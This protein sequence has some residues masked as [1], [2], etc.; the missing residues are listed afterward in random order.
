LPPSGL[1]LFRE[2]ETIKTTTRLL[3]LIAVGLLGFG[4]ASAA[5]A[6]TLFSNLGQ[7]VDGAGFLPNTNRRLASDFRTGPDATIIT[8]ATLK[9]S[10]PDGIPHTF[11][12][13]IWSDNAGLP[14][15]MLAV[16]NPILLPSG[17]SPGDFATTPSGSL[18]LSPTTT[19]WQVL[20]VNEDKLFVIDPEWKFTQSQAAGAG[21]AFA[22]LP[23]TTPK[24]STNGG[25]SWQ[26]LAAGNFQFAI[27]GV[28]EPT[29]ALLLLTGPAVLLATGRNRNR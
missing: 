25:A 9:L 17:T 18:N 20:Q 4:I 23:S 28:P 15:T 3:R 6:A 29:A 26:D 1:A 13:S 19:Y 24:V 7:S 11:T 16:F 8:G 22:T 14:G 12:A 27:T 10:N 2:E 21:S 5:S